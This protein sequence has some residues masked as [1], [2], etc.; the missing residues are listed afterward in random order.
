MREF[1]KEVLWRCGYSVIF[2]IGF[3]AVYYI[4]VMSIMWQIPQHTQEN[5]M[6]AFRLLFVSGLMHSAIFLGSY[7]EFKNINNN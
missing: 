3:M 1:L 4:I 2:S 7:K 5:L 6:I